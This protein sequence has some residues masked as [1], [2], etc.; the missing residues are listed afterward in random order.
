M[1]NWDYTDL[2]KA[3]G[4]SVDTISKICLEKHQANPSTRIKLRAALESAG[5]EFLEMD[6]VRKK[7][8]SIEIFDGI[9]RLQEFKAFFCSYLAEHGGEACIST[10]DER[11]FQGYIKN[12]D[13]YRST[14]IDLVK[15]GKVTGRILATAG[16][17]KKTWADIRKAPE[18]IG[19][20]PVSFY[21]FGD[22]FALISFAKP[23]SPYVELH[24]SS[25]FAPDFKRLFDL[26]WTSGE[27]I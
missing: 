10:T 6:G 3:S 17:F 4:L 1:L 7:I 19:V 18:V 12:I 11:V 20:L 22:C 8:T 13:A 14:M 21:V 9:D 23:Q 15:S 27:E 26:A 2:A 25:V 24:K 16:N 5:L